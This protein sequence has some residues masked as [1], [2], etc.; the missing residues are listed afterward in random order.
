MTFEQIKEMEKY[1]N[2]T[3]DVKYEFTEMISDF[4]TIT[5]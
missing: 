1:T 5:M 4:L 2:N 3:G